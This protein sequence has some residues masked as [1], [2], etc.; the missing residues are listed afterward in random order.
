MKHTQ[1][2]DGTGHESWGVPAP[3]LIRVTIHCCL[4]AQKKNKVQELEPCNVAVV[5][6]MYDTCCIWLKLVFCWL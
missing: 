3:Q 2:I 5:N 4:A 6:D 1:R